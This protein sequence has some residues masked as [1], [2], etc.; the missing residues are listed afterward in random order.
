MTTDKPT[1]MNIKFVIPFMLEEVTDKCLEKYDL[2]WS[3]LIL[4]DNSKDSFG[5]KYEGRGAKIFYYP[6]N[7]GIAAAWNLGVKEDFD[8]LWIISSSMIFNKGFSELKEATKQA[9][10]WGLLTTEAWHCIGFTKKTFDLIG[11]FDEQFKP[12]YYEDNDFMYRIK[13]AGIHDVGHAALPKVSLDTTC[14]GQ[15]VTLKS[16]AITVRFDLLEDYY[17]RKWG[18]TPG[19]ETYLTPFNT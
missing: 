17:K 13:L 4:I 9:N 3:Q 14:Q 12:A 18:G 7:I 19:K 11:L 2:P 16:G 15:A 10:E 1:E 8:F 5:K 6:E